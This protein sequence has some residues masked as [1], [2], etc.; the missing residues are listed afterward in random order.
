M[1]MDFM[2]DQIFGVLEKKWLK[3]MRTNNKELKKK[4]VLVELKKLGINNS[5]EI[6]S[7][8][9]EYEIYIKGRRC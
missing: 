8:L 1:K 9:R 7:Y 2:K 5:S 3:N 6:N 4:E